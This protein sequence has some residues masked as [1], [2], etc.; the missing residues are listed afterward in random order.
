[1]SFYLAIESGNLVARGEY[2]LFGTTV[3]PQRYVKF[4]ANLGAATAGAIDCEQLFIDG[5]TMTADEVGFTGIGGPGNN[6]CGSTV[7]SW[8]GVTWT[9]E[10]L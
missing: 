7:A 6:I 8:S 3:N 5:I 4:S 2:R 1:V 9:A 10:V